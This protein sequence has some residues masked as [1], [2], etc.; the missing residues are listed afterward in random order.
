MYMPVPAIAQAMRAP[1]GPVAV[2]N[3]PGKLKIPAPTI[4]PMTMAISDE[5]GSF[6]SVAACVADVEVAAWAVMSSLP[7]RVFARS[8]HW[9]V[10]YSPGHNE[11]CHLSRGRGAA[12]CG[13]SHNWAH[14]PK[15]RGARSLRLASRGDWITNRRALG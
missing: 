2:A 6:C 5:S 12:I 10:Q 3:R 9:A 7:I 1:K 4:E 13:E 11:W 15:L 8:P 14:D